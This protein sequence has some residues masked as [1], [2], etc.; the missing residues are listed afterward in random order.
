ML[1]ENGKNAG[2]VTLDFDRIDVRP[3]IGWIGR[4]PTPQARLGLVSGTNEFL[5]C[6]RITLAQAQFVDAYLSAH[7]I[8][9]LV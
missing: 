1:I 8:F 6:A 3:V 9:S 5:A 4:H 7:V 2:F